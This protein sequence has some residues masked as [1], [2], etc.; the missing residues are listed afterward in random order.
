MF[1]SHFKKGLELGETF[2]N[3]TD[4]MKDIGCSIHGNLWSN[5]GPRICT[6]PYL[7]RFREPPASR[8][9][10]QLPV[11]HGGNTGS[12]PVGDAKHSKELSRFHFGRLGFKKV[13]F[14]WNHS[15]S[16]CYRLEGSA[17]SRIEIRS[18]RALVDWR[19]CLVLD[20][21]EQERH[22]RAL[23]G[24]FCWRHC[25]GISIESDASRSVAEQF[26]HH[27]DIGAAD[28][29]KRR[30]AMAKGMPANAFCVWLDFW[31]SRA[32]HKSHGEQYR[33]RHLAQVD[34]VEGTN[35]VLMSEDGK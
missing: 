26:L 14:C 5:H 2:R 15:R 20:V 9:F 13:Q 22:D 24:A 27:F 29:Q 25:L 11:F 10:N 12:N 17:P 21:G 6:N 3:A 32:V 31:R 23:C 33:R 8:I 34:S 18:F 28:S 4:A 35:P 19:G 1:S 16:R 7:I 30:V